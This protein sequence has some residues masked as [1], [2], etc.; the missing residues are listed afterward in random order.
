[1]YTGFAVVL[2]SGAAVAALF[3]AHGNEDASA[4]RWTQLVIPAIFVIACAAMV[5]DTMLDAPKIAL[6]GVLLI[7]TGLPAYALCRRKVSREKI[8]SPAYKF[9]PEEV[10]GD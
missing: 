7:A 4:R 9:Q 10:S 1:M 8:L 2:S 6:V 3:F 5:I